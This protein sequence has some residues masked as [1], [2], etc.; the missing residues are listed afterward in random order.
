MFLMM[1][2]LFLINFAFAQTY[3]IIHQKGEVTILREGKTIPGVEVKVGD[4]VGVG[5][6]G[7]A[8][9]RAP[10]ETLKLLSDTKI[11]VSEISQNSKIN[12]LIGGVI[13]KIDKKGFTIKTKNSSM[14]VR[15]TQFFSSVDEKDVA[16]M[17]VNEGVVDAQG[18]LVPAG[19]GVFI[20]DGVSSKPKAFAWTKDI[21]WNMDEKNGELNSEIKIDAQYSDLLDHHYD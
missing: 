10:G 14:G 12:L 19:K 8:I 15:G 2:F 4:T 6:K 9:L 3:Q 21:N 5:N 18:V 20:K 17:C 1:L 7:L 16:W 13:S 11:E